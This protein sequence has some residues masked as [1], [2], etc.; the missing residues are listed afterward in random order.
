MNA[1]APKSERR[2]LERRPVLV[3]CAI[4]IV[5]A[6]CA[7][8]LIWTTRA[9]HRAYR[10]GSNSGYKNI[11]AGVKYMGDQ[12][13]VRCHGELVAAF[14]RTPMGSSLAPIA[15][16]NAIGSL[17]AGDKPHFV[18]QG[19]DYS[20]EDQH[21]RMIHVE[22]R[23]DG[24]GAEI[25]RN[26]A[27]VRFVLGSGRQAFAFLIERDGFL[28]ESPI[29]WYARERR[30]HL[31]PGYERRNYHFDRPILEDC[32]FCHTNR[33][34]RASSAL[35]Q[36]RPPIFHGYG[37]GCERC[38]GPGELHVRGTQ[39]VDG[40]DLT[41]VNPA[42]LRSSVSDAICE[43][44]HLIGR[45]V[46]R[47]GLRSE[48]FRPG[49]P[50]YQFWSAF[51]PSEESGGNRFASQAEQ[52]HESRC[53][54][55]SDGKLRCISCHNPHAT[56][57]AEEKV[58]YFRDRCLECHSDRGCSLPASVRVERKGADDC[59][60]CHMPQSHSSNNIHVATT[61]HR[62][63]R[64]GE[65]K[66]GAGSPAEANAMARTAPKLVNFHRRL[67]NDDE[68][69]AA[70]RDLGI[71]LSREGR[72]GAVVAL[73]LLEKALAAR[74]HDL[75]AWEAKAEA[76]GHLGRPA[77]GVAAYRKVLAENPT[78][79]TALGGA[80]KLAAKAGQHKDAAALWQRAIAVNPWRSDY[81][82]ELALAQLN[83]REWDAAASSCKEVLCLNPSFVEVRKWLV[84]SY[85]HLGKT[86]AARNELQVILGFDP[87][88]RAGLLRWFEA[89]SRAR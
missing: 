40:H 80:A 2:P 3:L 60:G 45:R 24:S 79:E 23:K 54:R 33:V 9:R 89:Q 83:L 75:T 37:I 74:P 22:S 78:R 87:P 39:I 27:E 44:C 26:N 4:L 8:V 34:E 65:A 35:N 47:L 18:A 49:L 12:A 6:A 36:Y 72:G 57:E 73:P 81:H 17:L 66:Q 38:H 31:S 63:S 13:C 41:I 30:W 42:N 11:H 77:E 32:L 1:I 82:A 16:E 46:N 64:H 51:V 19:L 84:R 56:P 88:D 58:G 86:E 67:M 20:V 52:M 55:A 85:L 28:F 53:Y 29:T 5:A 62:I 10:L 48:D 15:G 59:T 7:A 70:Q 76:L 21:G 50:F 69:A 43:Q 61:D 71:A 68:R 14:K 25:V